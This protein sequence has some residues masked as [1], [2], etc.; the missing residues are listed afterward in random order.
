MKQIKSRL[1]MAVL[2]LGLYA[3]VLAENKP[4]YPRVS[5]IGPGGNKNPTSRDEFILLVVEGAKISYETNSIPSAEVVEYVNNLLKERKVS[6]I[7]VYPREGIK[8]G[9]L[10]RAIDTLRKTTARSIGVS[11]LEIPVGRDP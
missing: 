8:Y 7:A 2:A 10:V 6:Y 5:L 11:M 3:D 9:D 1:L 4:E